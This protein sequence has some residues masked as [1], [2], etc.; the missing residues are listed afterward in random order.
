LQLLE[1]DID[2]R[3]VQFFAIIEEDIAA[4]A[5]QQ[6]H[7][8]RA[9]GRAR[10]R[11][12]PAGDGARRIVILERPAWPAKTRRVGPQ[13]DGVGH[14]GRRQRIGIEKVEAIGAVEAAGALGEQLH[15]PLASSP[16]T[17]ATVKRAP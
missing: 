1:R 13:G 2:L 15:L 17:S 3:H 9:E 6:Q 4:Q 16:P 14:H 11:R 5:G 12:R 7:L 8:H 10:F